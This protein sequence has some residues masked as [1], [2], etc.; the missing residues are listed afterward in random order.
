MPKLQRHYHF[1]IGSDF[2]L[3]TAAFFVASYYAR[4]RL[5][6]HSAFWDLGRMEAA[7]LAGLL[8]AWYFSTRITGLYDALRARFARFGMGKLFMNVLLQAV[9]SIVILFALKTSVLNRYFIALYI[10]VQ[11]ILLGFWRAVIPSVL[12]WTGLR[13]GEG[14]RNLVIIGAGRTAHEFRR[15]LRSVPYL[16]ITVLGFVD[17]EPKPELGGQYLGTIDD[18]DGLLG[19]EAVAEVV[20]AM[21]DDPA[22]R[23]AK[24]ISVCERHL[25]PVRIIP[26][27]YRFLSGR[28]DMSF[29]GRFPLFSQ[30]RNPLEDASWRG[31]KRFL[32]LVVTVPL[33]VL[34]FSWLW[35]ILAL[36]IKLDSRGP[37]LFKQERWGA[38][39]R[40]FLCCKF[41]SMVH[42]VDQHDENGRF[43]QVEKE[44][45][46]LTRVGRFLR[47]TSLDELP[48]FLNVLRGEMSI[49]GPRPHPV[50][51]DVEFGET[52][53]HLRLRY[54]VRPG[55]TGWAQVHGLRGPITEPALMQKRVEYDIWYVENWSLG[56]D[57]NIALR[58]VW[59]LIRGDDN[60]Y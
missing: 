59:L 19:R 26:S 42:D 38:H 58:T 21:P 27:C 4:L 9:A 6:A 30:R 34:V 29:F 8:L 11:V 20:I 23:I 33:F 36:A 51:L 35:P 13:G 3:L 17:D 52:V 22:S 14:A 54:L 7:L 41:R 60:A 45:A 25:V 55:L 12:R 39:S 28:Y 43:L 53:P 10:I 2:I 15:L 40:R 56:L 50:P 31:F 18:L 5:E 57:A 16:G 24:V 47:R 46:R 37:V 32:D 1:R 49:V 44:D 48:Q